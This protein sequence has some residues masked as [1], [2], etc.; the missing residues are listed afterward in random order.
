LIQVETN[1]LKKLS[2]AYTWEFIDS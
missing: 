2:R 1:N